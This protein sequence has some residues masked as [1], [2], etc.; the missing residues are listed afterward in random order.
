MASWNQWIEVFLFIFGVFKHS[1]TESNIQFYPHLR[2]LC[3]ILFKSS[4]FIKTHI[5]ITVPEIL[6]RFKNIRQYIAIA[7]VSWSQK[8]IYMF[9]V[10][11]IIDMK[12]QSFLNM[13][14]LH[15]IY[16]FFLSWVFCTSKGWS[17]E[18]V[19]GI[20][21]KSVYKTEKPQSER[22]TLNVLYFI[23]FF[24]YKISP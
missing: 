10:N 7:D 8:L 13:S 21:V 14:F 4:S 23:S 15:L 9:Y 17:V 20:F 12:Q 24:F 11:F 19:N 6:L 2:R 16:I 18:L 3:S 5:C 1:L 22:K